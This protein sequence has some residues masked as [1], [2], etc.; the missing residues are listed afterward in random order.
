[1]SSFAAIQVAVAST[2]TAQNLPSNP[3]VESITITAPSTNVAA[4]VIGNTASHDIDRV[5]SG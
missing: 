1:M 2:G 5:H 4:V 3:V